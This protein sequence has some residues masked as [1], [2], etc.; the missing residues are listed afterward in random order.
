MV[1]I[2]GEIP[3]RQALGFLRGSDLQLLVGFN[4]LGANLQVPAK[5][6]EYFGVGKPIL[7]LAPQVSAIADVIKASG[8]SGD[9][10]DPDSPEEIYQALCRRASQHGEANGAASAAQNPAS[11]THFTRKEQVRLIAELLDRHAAGR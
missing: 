4:G 3:H 1:Q 10:C 11:L 2:G 9:V 7:A 8:M 6:F 5:L